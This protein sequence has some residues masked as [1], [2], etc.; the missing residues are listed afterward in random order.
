[1]K[2]RFYFLT[3]L[4]ILFSI[5]ASYALTAGDIA[6]IGVNADASKSMVFVALADIPAST[7]ISFTD[8]AWN[9]STEAWRTGE[10]TFTWSNSSITT[11]GTVV[12]ITMGAP[13]SPF[14]VNVGSV[15][16][17]TNFN[18]ATSGDQV[19]AYEGSTAPTTNSSALWLYGFSLENWVW[20]NNTNTSDI[21]TA[22]SGAN[23]GLTSSSTEKDNGYFANGSS[24]QTSVSVSGTKAELL[25]LFTD[26]T[27]YYTNDTGPLTFPTYT[28][29]VTTGGGNQAPAISNIVLN[30][31]ADYVSTTTVEVSA[32]ITDSDGTVDT[33][34]VKWGTST[35]TYPN[36]INMSL[37]SG[38]TYITDSDIPAQSDGTTV[39]FVVYAVDDADDSTTSSEQSYTV[40]NPSTTTLPY[41]ETFDADLGD[42][43]AYNVA[44]TNPW[45]FG[46]TSASCNG[47]GGQNPEEQW[48]VLPGINMDNYSNERMSFNNYVKYGTIDTNNYLKLYYSTNYYGIG[49]PSGASWTEITFT[50]PTTGTVGSTEL[51]A[52]SGI[53]DLSGISGTSVYFAFKYYSTN[54]PSLWRV[55]DI[56]I[57]LASPVILVDPSTLTGFTYEYGS[58][59]STEQTFTI[60]GADLSQNISIAASTN[61]EI[62]LTSGS[63]YTTPL[64]LTQ[65]GGV[66]ATDTVYVRLKSGLAIGDYNSEV[67]TATSSGATNKTVTCSG[68]VSTPPPPD[69]PDATAPS[70]IDTDSFYANWDAVSGATSYRLDVYTSGGYASDL[71]FS[72]YI[73]GS[74]NNKVLEIFNG[75]GATVD[76]GNYTVYLYA[77]GSA[78]PTA[79]LAMSGSLAHN[80]VYVIANSSSSAPFLAL[81]DITSGVANFNGDDALGLENELTKGYADILGQIGSDPGSAWGTAPLTTVNQ[82][83]VRKSSVTGGVTSNPTGFPTLSTEWDAY[84]IDTITYLGS[85]TMSSSNYV[86]GYQDLN[87]G[88]VTSYEVTDLSSGTTYYYVV[89]A[90]GAYGTSANS[91]EQSATTDAPL[92]VELSS[93]TA[94]VTSQYFVTLKWTTQSETNMQGYYIFRNNVNSLNSAYQIPSLIMATNTSNETSYAFTDQEVEPGNTYFYWLQAMEL[95]GE[96][97]FHG[98][99]SVIINT[100]NDTPTPV[101]PKVT[102]LRDA[103]PNPFNPR[104]YIPYTIKDAGNVKIEIFNLKGQVIWSESQNHS[105]PGYYQTNWDGRDMNGNAVSSGVYYYRM[106]SGKYTS[107]KKVVL[108][109]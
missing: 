34:L 103:Y 1:M 56:S 35:G 107:S 31:A 37:D 58:G 15:T 27:K 11:K 90:V 19:L 73:E 86:S 106:T 25:A 108:M 84:D 4:F 32:D 91:D 68:S 102:E 101:I 64:V 51:S 28:I 47:F 80:D 13:T 16:T 60:S 57:Y 104:T 12:T 109:K 96:S 20:A 30:P 83:L 9:A 40:R 65:V 48:L 105:V 10:G 39:Y 46:T 67:I 7:T 99:I 66:V 79:T 55:D 14:T 95:N 8:N 41:S 45:F 29:T 17:N 22:L 38:D 81:A 53:L 72:E 43:Y 98:P 89:R 44:G 71:F 5:S 62:S 52:F 26:N 2:K 33:T 49:A 6:I 74:S 75:T 23:V 54:S 69:P 82:T 94:I 42:C 85:H 92:P 61:Y 93:F 24:S 59:P 50:Q 76:L 77:N 88:N 97:N 100:N 18:M 3:F 70:G 36:T 87:V 21:P 78:T 63:G